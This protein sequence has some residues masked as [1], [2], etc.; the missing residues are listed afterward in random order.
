MEGLEWMRLAVFAGALA[1]LAGIEMLVPRR[2]MREG[3]RRWPA[4]L[5][6]V[7]LDALIVRLL[8]PMGAIGAASWAGAH[9]LGLM[10][11]LGV[12]EVPAVVLSM[13][14]LDLVLYLQ[15]RA[16]HALPWLWRFHL[17]HHTD[18]EL[19]VSTALRFH[20]VEIL[21]SMLIKMTAAAALGAPPVA[22]FAFELLLNG[23]AMFNHANIRLPVRLDSA[24]RLLVVTPDMHRVHHSIHPDEMN[25]NFGFNLSLWD[26]ILGSYRARPRDG[27]ERMVLGYAPLL[28]APVRRLDYLLSL[29]FVGHPGEDRPSA[30]SRA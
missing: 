4:N 12:P 7:A 27:H 9:Q 19:D 8:L 29:P 24:L 15:H 2:R 3:K 1:F 22:V 5:G 11:W 23:M 16:F 26:R 13:L 6:I 17:V 18:R 14:A 21:I 30:A 28:N 25:R 20:P 10:H